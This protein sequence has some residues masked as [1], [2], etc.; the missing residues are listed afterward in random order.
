MPQ[1]LKIA[2]W[3]VK[4]PKIK[5]WLNNPV[6]INKIQDINADIWVFTETNS[7]I[8]PGDVYSS[9]A[10]TAIDNYHTSGESC[11]TIWSRYPIKEQLPTF[12]PTLTVCVEIASPIGSLLVYGSIIPWAHEGVLEKEAKVWQRHYESINDHS[13]DWY[14]FSHNL[15][16]CAAGDFNECLNK[17]F[18]YGTTK[19]RELLKNALERS[20]LKCVT[21]SEEIGYNI[22]H[23]CLSSGWAAKVSKVDKWQAYNANGKPVSDHQGISIEIDFD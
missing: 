6:I 22:D 19:G 8:N 9:V 1:S 7:I 5:G 11:V 15:P 14:K 23:I 3:N 12:D 10:S 21:A 20:N 17:P 2:T 16:I 18:Q 13:E 4:R